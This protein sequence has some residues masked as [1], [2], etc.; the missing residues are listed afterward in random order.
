[1]PSTAGRGRQQDP[2][3]S[4]NLFDDDL[5]GACD[6]DEQH[7]CGTVACLAGTMVLLDNPK[8]YR[9][10]IKREEGMPERAARIAGLTIFQ[11]NSLFYLLAWP[12]EFFKQY[13]FMRRPAPLLS[14]RER[15]EIFRH[16]ALSLRDRIKH[17]FRTGL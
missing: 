1:M 6:K 16:R 10:L 13:D 7:P 14:S 2:A 12:R 9:R 11:Q 5:G 15:N 4:R 3:V 17:F 8:T